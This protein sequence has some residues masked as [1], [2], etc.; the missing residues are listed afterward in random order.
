[1]NRK[2]KQIDDAIDEFLGFTGTKTDLQFELALS[3]LSENLLGEENEYY[4]EN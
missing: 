4:F 2:K 3:E 1:M